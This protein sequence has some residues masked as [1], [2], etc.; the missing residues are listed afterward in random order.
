LFTSK[1]VTSFDNLLEIYPTLLTDGPNEY[2]Y[3]K[4]LLKFSN[5]TLLR[6]LVARRVFKIK[7]AIYVIGCGDLQ[8]TQEFFNQI[9][10][11]A[12]R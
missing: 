1:G 5:P 12:A 2:I 4:F 7:D 3:K 10:K 11:E 9:G 8:T 6:K